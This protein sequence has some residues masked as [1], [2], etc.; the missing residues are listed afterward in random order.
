MSGITVLFRRGLVEPQEIEAASRHFHVEFQR[1][2]CGAGDLVIPRY[3]ALPHNQELCLDLA[4]LGASPI[5]S[6]RQHEYAAKLSNWYQDLEGLTPK[7]WFSLESLPRDGTRFVVKGE[8]NSKKL[9]WNTLMFAPDYRAAAEVYGKLTQDSVIGYQDIVF[10]EYVPLVRLEEGLNGMPISKEFRFFMLDGQILAGGFYWSSHID[11][12]DRV[13][14]ISEVPAAFLE[15]VANRMQGQI[16]F[17]VVDVAQTV[18]GD[19]IVVEVNDGCQSGLSEVSPDE[20]YQ[21][22]AKKLI[23]R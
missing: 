19:W 3:S 23:A 18:S 12:L 7:T 2:R 20:L 13:P 10:R 5:N 9:Q 22:L 14:I 8:T 4:E 21:N 1:T 11:D 6:H 16:R 17:V 15:T